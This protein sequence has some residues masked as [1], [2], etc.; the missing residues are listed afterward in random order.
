[1]SEPDCEKPE[2]PEYLLSVVA[3][4]DGSQ[5]Y[6]HLDTDGLTELIDILSQLRDNLAIDYCDHDHL[7]TPDWGG[8]EL[9][10]S[11]LDT[12][13]QQNCVQVGHLK[14]YAWTEEW[15]KKYFPNAV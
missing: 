5:V 3:E 11:M 1:M 7:L 4:S 12:E 8:W 13:K 9:S 2:P 15:K 6:M 10:S 14:I